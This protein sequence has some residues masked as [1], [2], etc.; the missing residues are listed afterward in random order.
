MP[1]TSRN[2]LP[3]LLESYLNLPRE[4]TLILLTGVLNASSNWLVVK[5]L[6]AL[7]ADG[8]KDGRQPFRRPYAVG[9]ELS[10]DSGG[11][12][13][14]REGGDVATSEEYGVVLV[15][16]MREFD[17]WRTEGRKSGNI[18]LQRLAQQRRFVF[19]DGLTNLFNGDTLD[20]TAGKDSPKTTTSPSFLDKAQPISGRSAQKLPV[21]DAPHTTLPNRSPSHP[22]LQPASTISTEPPSI[23]TLT[24]P[25]TNTLQSSLSHALTSLPFPNR[26]LILDTPSLLFSTTTSN[27]STLLTLLTTLNPQP[28]HI[29]ISDLTDTPLLRPSYQLSI[30]HD[31]SVPSFEH[32]RTHHDDSDTAPTVAIAQGDPIAAAHSMWI[33]SLAHRASLV[34]S[35]RPL[36]SGAARDVSGV[37]RVTRGEGLWDMGDGGDGG[38]GD[39]EWWDEIQEKE[40]LYWVGGDGG[41]KVFGRGEEV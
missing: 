17:F 18:D 16:W 39:G 6:S 35:V 41:V 36:G 25:S 7:L 10:Y 15:S 27:P 31:F 20:S 2:N 11:L 26:I 3:P 34:M 32:H 30:S 8:V 19:V 29:I 40:V 9:E 38:D 24:N 5:Y 12:G 4:S 22:A 14:G 13:N 23:L 1:P 21:R 28:T 33:T 37:V